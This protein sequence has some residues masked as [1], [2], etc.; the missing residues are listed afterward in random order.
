MLL[1]F[2]WIGVDDNGSG[3]V[4]MLEA[5]RILAGLKN[6][7]Y[8]I[9]FIAFDFEEWETGGSYISNWNYITFNF[10]SSIIIK[11]VLD[12]FYSSILSWY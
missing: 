2:L 1:K 6:R 9:L 4:A 12:A 10:W 3:V 8:S 7:R 11:Y 5:A